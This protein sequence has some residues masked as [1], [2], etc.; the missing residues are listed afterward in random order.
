MTSNC[1]VSLSLDEIAP[2]V[3]AI[4]PYIVVLALIYV[5]NQISHTVGQRVSTQVGTDITDQLYMIEGDLVAGLQEVI[6]ETFIEYFISIY[7][8]GFAFVLVFPII[9]YIVVPSQQ[10]LVELFVA[11]AI[12]Y[13]GGGICYLLFI[14]YGP[15]NVID[16]GDEPMHELYPQLTALTRSVNSSANVFPLLAVSS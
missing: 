8:F 5:F 11:Y 14:A 7:V 2:K 15:R 13:G 10:Y 9:A 1:F 4:S 6:P 3:Y 12:N 16:H